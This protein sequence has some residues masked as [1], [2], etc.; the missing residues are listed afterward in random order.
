MAYEVQPGTANCWKNEFKDAEN[1]P[2]FKT[3]QP[4]VIDG[5]EYDVALWERKDKNGEKYF[6]IKV[7]TKFVKAEEPKV[8]ETPIEI[9]DDVP[10]NEDR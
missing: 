5:K 4:I 10:F 7:A 3:N 9:G 6:G 1:K 8:E 2:D